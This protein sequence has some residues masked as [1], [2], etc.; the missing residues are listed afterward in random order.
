VASI[1]DALIP[2]SPWG[3]PP[4]LRVAVLDDYQNIALTMGDRSAL[5]GKAEIVAF[6]DHID[7]Q[8]QLI[9]RLRISPTLSPMRERT[10]FKRDGRPVIAFGYLCAT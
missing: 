9:D 7:D 4:M 6:P 5:Y 10:A 3:G 8:D 2:S 1:E